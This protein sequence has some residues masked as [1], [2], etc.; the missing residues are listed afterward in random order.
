MVACEQLMLRRF[1]EGCESIDELARDLEGML[2]KSSPGLP[3]EIREVEL[4]F[5]LMNSLPKKV[6]FQLKVSYVETISKAREI[7]LIYSRADRHHPISQ[8]QTKP[9][10]LQQDRLDR[11]EESLQQMTEQLAAL[12]THHDDTRRCF[13]CGREDMWLKTVDLRVE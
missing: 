1:R 7:L 9:K 3:A 12:R 8:I 10:V 4:R 2:D 6:A 5:H 13:R 11:M